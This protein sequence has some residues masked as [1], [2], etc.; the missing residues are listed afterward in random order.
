M[1]DIRIETTSLGETVYRDDKILGIFQQF[2][3]GRWGYYP[4]ESVRDLL[5][6][7]NSLEI[8]KEWVLRYYNAGGDL[9]T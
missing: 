2:V 1:T 5:F 7:D 6:S 4:N 3:S 8:L 9:G